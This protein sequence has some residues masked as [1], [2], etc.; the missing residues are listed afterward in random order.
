[1]A[2]I[3]ALEARIKE[4]QRH[5]QE[6]QEAIKV[7]QQCL[8]KETAFKPFKVGDRVWLEKTN[9]PLPYESSKLAPK[10][11]GPFPVTQKI[12]D[13]AYKLKLPSTW[14][15]HDV[16]HAG[17]LTLYKENDKYG[18]NFLEPPPELLDGEPEWEVE[19]IMGQRK[20]RNKQQ[21][22][23]RWKDYSPAHDSWE[24]ESNIHA[25]LLIK[26]YQQR[27]EAQSAAPRNTVIIPK[28]T[29]AQSAVAK[30][31]VSTRK[32]D[33]PLPKA[34]SADHQALP[35]PPSLSNQPLIS[36]RRRSVRILKQPPTY[37]PALHALRI[38]TL[39]TVDEEEPVPT[40]MSSLPSTPDRLASPST[41]DI[42][43]DST[44]QVASPRL[45]G[46]GCSS[47]TTRNPARSGLTRP[48]S[49]QATDNSIGRGCREDE[50]KENIRPSDEDNPYCTAN[51]HLLWQLT[52]GA[53]Q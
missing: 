27:L 17:L 24:N 3:P 8:I 35:R 51:L 45:Q 33:K 16:F 21:Y 44:Q 28:R 34:Q 36:T 2:Q 22:L 47:R 39:T 29:K 41:I 12:S 46:P 52:E 31:S 10:R 9:L 1:M 49:H 20:F 15:I 14:K 7:S 13:V 6:A 50:D 18:P 30:T 40:P 19:G 5:C 23:V 42:D 48:V 53:I 38:R 25:P 37:K 11:Y 4:I 43:N 26:A 32:N